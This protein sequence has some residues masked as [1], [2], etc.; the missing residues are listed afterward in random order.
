M[1]PVIRSGSKVYQKAE[2]PLID[3]DTEIVSCEI[4]ISTGISS[5]RYGIQWFNEDNDNFMLDEN[6]NSL[7]SNVTNISSTFVINSKNQYYFNPSEIH[8]CCSVLNNRIL[9]CSLAYLTSRIIKKATTTT[10]STTTTTIQSTSTT[11]ILVT[12]TKSSTNISHT[13]STSTDKKTDSIA[14]TISKNEPLITNSS[15]K[16]SSTLFTSN[17]IPI[18]IVPNKSN[19]CL[20]SNLSLFVVSFL[21]FISFN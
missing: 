1:V 21:L 19:Q 4:T 3:I 5:Q 15:P 2:L 16:A 20:N 6:I 9:N 18:T 11:N 12:T 13:I 8:K 7:K 17:D 14:T 10:T